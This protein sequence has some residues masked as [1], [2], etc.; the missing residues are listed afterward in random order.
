[1]LK[2]KINFKIHQIIFKYWLTLRH[3]AMDDPVA[4]KENAQYN[5]YCI[6]S[7][8]FLLL[9]FHSFHTCFMYSDCILHWVELFSKKK[10][11]RRMYCQKAYWICIQK[12]V[13]DA[14]S[15]ETS[16]HI[17]LILSRFYKS[18]NFRMTFRCL[19]LNQKTNEN[20]SVFLPYPSKI[21][22]IKK[23]ANY[24]IRR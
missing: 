3:F 13:F 24:Y 23:N 17:T 15:P 19:H 10:V 11:S 22:Q 5:T 12:N 1:M 16:L 4:E 18:L 2:A 8:D 14:T 20:I 9:F 7:R 6:Q 21:G